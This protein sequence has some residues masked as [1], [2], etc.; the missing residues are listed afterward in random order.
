MSTHVHH[1]GSL[2]DALVRGHDGSLHNLNT[3]GAHTVAGSQVQVQRVHGTVQGGV[4]ELLVHVVVTR[5]AL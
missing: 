3:G 1:G 5:S 2:A 4:T